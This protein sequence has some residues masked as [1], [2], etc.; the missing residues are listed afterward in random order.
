MLIVCSHHVSASEFWPHNFLDS[1]NIIII[2]IKVVII[3]IAFKMMIMIIVDVQGNI[4][5]ELSKLEREGGGGRESSRKHIELIMTLVSP[6]SHALI[7]FKKQTKYDVINEN[8]IKICWNRLDF[9]SANSALI[10]H[11]DYLQELTWRDL[12][13]TL[14]YFY[15]RFGKTGNKKPATFFATLLHNELNSDVAWF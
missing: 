10:S 2:I 6:M 12:S 9:I 3:F 5:L 1:S 14:R 13:L 4:Y 11:L 7:P 8:K 15:W